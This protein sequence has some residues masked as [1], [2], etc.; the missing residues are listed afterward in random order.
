MPSEF[1]IVL[2]PEPGGCV[3]R[4][5]IFILFH[6]CFLSCFSAAAG[7]KDYED[8][9]QALSLIKEAITA[10]DA[11]VNEC[12]KEQRLREIV[13]RMEL[14]SSGKFKNGLV[15]RKEDM[16][17]RRLLVDGMLCWKAAS[18]RLKGTT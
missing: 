7:T 13:T 2:L 6:I 5:C 15:F 14:K 10:V 17:Q 4:N 8:L 18:G 12:E 1:K 11:K 9:T 3:R 16:L